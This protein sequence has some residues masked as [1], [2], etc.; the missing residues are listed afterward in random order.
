[1]P[2][3]SGETT[4]TCA[5]ASTGGEMLD[6]QRIGLQV[7][8]AAAERVL[9]R[10]EI[11]HVERHDAIGA[12]R[13][14]QLRDVARRDRIARLALAVLACVGEIGNDGGDASR[15]GVLERAE[16]EQQPD[17]LVVARSASRRRTANE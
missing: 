7:L 5:S 13:F 8:G 3:A 9:V 12:D 1:M 15:R 11:V 4:L 10:R 6:E 16:E 2:P 17:E 14:E